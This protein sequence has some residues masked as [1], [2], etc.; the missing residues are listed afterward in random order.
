M[1]KVRSN[2]VIGRCM[3]FLAL[4]YL[5]VMVYFM[6]I[7]CELCYAAAGLCGLLGLLHFVLGVLFI[8]LDNKWFVRRYL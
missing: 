8:N 6:S 1:C 5:G 4:G 3:Y 7:G 2:V